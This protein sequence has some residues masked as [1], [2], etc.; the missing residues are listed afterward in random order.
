M[1]FEKTYP[2]YLS[3]TGYVMSV[4]VADKIYKSALSMPL[5]H[6]EDVYVTGLCAKNAKIRPI[7]H[8]G[9]SYVARKFDICVLKNSITNHKV[10]TS[11]MYAIWNKLKNTNITCSDSDS[12]KKLNRKTRNVGYYLVKRRTISNRNVCT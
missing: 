1:F 10:N 11:M 2:N 8:P 7:N 3:G 9:F 12:D 6:L 5:L 4:D